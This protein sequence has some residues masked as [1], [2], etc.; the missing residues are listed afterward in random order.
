[1]DECFIKE[2]LSTIRC[3]I[4][5]DRYQVKNLKILG[6]QD[7][8]WFV[9]ARCP[10]CYKRAFVVAI[11]KRDKPPQIITE[12]SETETA[13]F[14]QACAINSDDI[15]DLHNFLKDFDGDFV[16]LFSNTKSES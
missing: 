3:S 1:M 16:T 15:L 7:D 4:C 12:L 2:L 13:K 8:T 10:A 6:H 9:N 5:G 14:S 11:I